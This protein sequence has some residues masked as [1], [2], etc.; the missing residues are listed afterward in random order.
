[1]AVQSLIEEAKKRAAWSI[2]MGV[3]TAALGAFLIVY[4]LATAKVTT[5]LLG[6]VLILI[7]ISQLVFALH[8]GTPGG[9]LPKLLNA[10]IFGII[11]VALAFAPMAGVEA[12]TALLGMLLLIQAGLATVTAFQIRPLTGWGWFLVEAATSFA[13]GMLIL[14][15][16]PS[17]SVWAI[18]M[19]VGVA[20][21]M[22]GIVRIVVAAKVGSGASSLERVSSSAA[23]MRSEARN[24]QGSFS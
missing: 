4:P 5:A 17:S 22:C 19:M 20:V 3:L 7:A 9:F 24:T 11:G 14:V 10:V 8:S 6:W 18:G 2:I 1:M 13:L 12:L 23:G 15:E 16:W 21:L